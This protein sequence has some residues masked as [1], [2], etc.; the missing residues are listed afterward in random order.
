[1]A[2][3]DPVAGKEKSALCQGCHGEDGMSAAPNF[4]RLAGQYAGYIKKQIVDFQKEYRKDDTMS[5]MAATVTEKQDLED[6][7]AYFASQKIMVGEKTANPTGH[8][9]Y[10][11]GNPTTNLYGCVNCHGDD[12][13]GKSPTN[14]VFPIIGGQHKDYLIK[15][16]NDFR[17]GT[18]A[19]DPAGMMGD[20]AKKMTDT[21]IAAV[22]DYLSGL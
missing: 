22:A 16:L 9:L 11:K 10:V 5:G 3:G 20:I 14:Y 12:G 13:K 18:R 6:I 19:N 7:A 21:E 1:L 4:P 15:Q 2:V 8:N 17:S